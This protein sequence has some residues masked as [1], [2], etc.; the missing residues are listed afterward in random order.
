MLHVIAAVAA[1][2]EVVV[3]VV[4]GLTKSK[5]STQLGGPGSQQGAQHST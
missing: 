5:K 2:A 3:V 4:I 1:A